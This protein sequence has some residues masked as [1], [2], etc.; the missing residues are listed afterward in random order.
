[1]ATD[2]Q[3]I[4]ASPGVAPVATMDTSDTDSDLDSSIRWQ[5]SK[6]SAPR[7]SSRNA[8]E[9]LIDYVDAPVLSGESPKYVSIHPERS[10]ANAE[11]NL[12]EEPPFFSLNALLTST[13]PSI[14]EDTANNSASRADFAIRPLDLPKAPAATTQPSTAST[15]GALT[16]VSVES[17][18]ANSGQRNTLAP[19]T[20]TDMTRASN[21]L[22]D[23]SDSSMP[24][25]RHEIAQVIA[26]GGENDPTRTALDEQPGKC[27]IAQEPNDFPTAPV[28]KTQQFGGGLDDSTDSKRRDSVT[29]KDEKL[30]ASQVADKDD[31]INLDLDEPAFCAEIDN[32]VK[33]MCEVAKQMSAF[34]D[35]ILAEKGLDKPLFQWS[36][37]P[38]YSNLD[39]ATI[40]LEKAVEKLKNTKLE[41]A[42]LLQVLAS[43]Y[44][45]RALKF[46]IATSKIATCALETMN[47]KTA[48]C[49]E[50][51]ESSSLRKKYKD[52][53]KTAMTAELGELLKHS[54]AAT[55]CVYSAMDLLQKIV[56]CEH[57]SDQSVDYDN[58]IGQG[59]WK[60]WLLLAISL[61]S[62]GFTFFGVYEHLSPSSEFPASG[63]SAG[64]IPKGYAVVDIV[65]LQ[66]TLGETVRAV[67]ELNK[68][69]GLATSARLKYLEEADENTGQRIDNIWDSLGPPDSSGSYEFGLHHGRLNVD[70]AQGIEEVRK[71]VKTQ[72][73]KVNH[74]IARLDKVNDGIIEL[75]KHIQ[76]V[77]I[78]LTKRI[79]YLK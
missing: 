5:G 63:T 73:G 34:H 37:Y 49:V 1:M 21:V 41:E 7:R 20:N 70:L 65:A 52:I 47:I 48:T 25:L 11:E 3:D 36:R 56:Y 58:Y 64:T 46:S 67:A 31:K 45:D 10:P 8:Y 6:I 23:Y 54:T 30:G 4:D 51:V 32:V 17:A 19:A 59:S 53:A 15:F 29:N 39:R 9:A 76:R 35:Y 55:S 50:E 27:E 18:A 57:D 71:D 72:L 74:E 66:S 13:T 40:A 26:A 60:Y 62:L 68:L 44:F 24:Q 12:S 2:T 22:S 77:D 78:R 69:D 16:P 79:D 75:K 38:G 61:L 33:S 14:K 43:S 42:L 28:S